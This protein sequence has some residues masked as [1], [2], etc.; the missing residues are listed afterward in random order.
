MSGDRST[1]RCAAGTVDINDIR[2]RRRR[3]RRRRRCHRR[4]GRVIFVRHDSR[5]CRRSLV[6]SLVVYK[7]VSTA[8]FLQ[9]KNA[10]AFIV[11]MSG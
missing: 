9:F 7:R 5:V 8:R 6:C 3:H 4:C 2:R 1:G 10:I 11:A